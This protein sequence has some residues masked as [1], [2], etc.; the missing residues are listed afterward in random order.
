MLTIELLKRLLLLR[1][2][3]EIA[4]KDLATDLENVMK[5]VRCLEKNA[6][7]VAKSFLCVR[8]TSANVTAVSA[9]KS[10]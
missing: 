6:R 8:S 7:A 10:E 5:T 4:M 1:K 2:M 3:K 9:E